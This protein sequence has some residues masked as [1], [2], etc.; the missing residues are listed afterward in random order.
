MPILPQVAL[1]FVRLL[2]QFWLDYDVSKQVL[3]DILGID[4]SIESRDKFGISSHKMARLHQ[5]AVEHIKDPAMGIRLGQ[6]I[7]KSGVSIAD[8]LM[9]SET[10]ATG[11]EV[12]ITRSKVITESGYFE[13][14][15]VD[16]DTMRLSFTQG[17]GIVFSSYQKD[18]IFSAIQHWFLSVFP[19][20]NQ[21]L[22]YFFDA[23]SV[24]G[25][26]H[27]K[28]L[29]CSIG[30]ADDTYIEISKCLLV[31]NNPYAD[32]L[33]F[34]KN[35][36][37]TDK[38]I[39]K[40]MQRLDLYIEVRAA[41]KRCLLQRSATQENVAQQ[42]NLTIRNLQRRLKEV[43]IT[44]QAILDDSREALALHL[45]KDLDIPLYEISFLV[46]FTEPS[47]FY[48]AF[49]RWTG[50]RPG[51]YRQDVMQQS[52]QSEVDGSAAV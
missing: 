2:Y 50:K 9:K 40:R 20:A 24:S 26:E 12:L 14:T 21:H 49:R 35:I 34:N 27:E 41:I 25:I 38:I 7:A 46:G 13:L 36:I 33:L 6:Y 31:R 29:G 51:D 3:D 19:D 10:L 22:K 18:M 4:I 28:L 42:L 17:E 39:A 47:A 1:P 32:K 43:G 44:Y 30:K 45:I 8:M 48:K 15:D 16:V 11:I 52:D 23:N 37:E 5:V